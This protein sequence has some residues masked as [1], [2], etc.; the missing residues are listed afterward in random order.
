MSEASERISALEL[1]NEEFD[2]RIDLQASAGNAVDTKTSLFIGFAVIALQLILATDRSSPW[3]VVAFVAFAVALLAGF[4]CI[5]LRA[6]K[7]APKPTTI[8]AFYNDNRD[9]EHFY[10][11]ILV[12]LVGAKTKAIDENVKEDKR[13]SNAWHAMVGALA[14]ALVFSTI[15]ILE[16]SSGDSTKPSRRA[17]ERTVAYVAAD[18]E[19]GDSRRP[20]VDGLRD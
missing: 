3:D 2:K 12:R 9:T 19:P 6:F 1:L 7:T 17:C 10:E 16:A 5:R 13:K 15:S 20:C 4:E 14:V 18:W 11:E 8:M